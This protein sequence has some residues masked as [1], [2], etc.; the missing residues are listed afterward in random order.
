MSTRGSDAH[1]VCTEHARSCTDVSVGSSART[2]TFAVSAIIP[3]VPPPRPVIHGDE[4]EP[5][6]PTQLMVA[7]V[8]SF[9]NESSAQNVRAPLAPMYAGYVSPPR[10]D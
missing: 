6:H 5:V 2:Y 3:Y 10:S 4:P 9:A 7:G 1:A 8:S